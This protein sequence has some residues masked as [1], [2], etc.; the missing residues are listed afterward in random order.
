[1][2]TARVV[3]WFWRCRVRGVDEDGWLLNLVGVKCV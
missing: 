2:F 3:Y 1:M